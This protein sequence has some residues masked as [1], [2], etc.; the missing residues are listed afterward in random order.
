[1]RCKCEFGFMVVLF[2]V[3]DLAEVR[4]ADSTAG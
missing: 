1:M 3:N 2:G 4:R